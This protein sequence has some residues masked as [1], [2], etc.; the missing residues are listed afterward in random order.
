MDPL[1]QIYAIVQALVGLI[2]TNTAK[3][4]ALTQQLA[5]IQADDDATHKALADAQQHQAETDK[6]AQALLAQLQALQASITPDST[7]PLAT[8]TADATPSPVIP[9]A[10]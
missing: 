7:T 9:I 4:T 3:L 5:T 10:S 1:A 8:S 2:T 6:T